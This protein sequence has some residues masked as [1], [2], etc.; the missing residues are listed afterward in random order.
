MKLIKLLDTHYIVVDNSEIKVGDT[1]VEK[2]LTDEYELFE[3]HTLNDID[4]VRQ[5]KITHS[6]VPLEIDDKIPHAV[7]HGD[8]IFNTFKCFD[9]IK[10][11]S[12]SEIEEAI[13][14]YN[15]ENMAYQEISKDYFLGSGS[16]ECT[17][18]KNFYVKGFNAYKELVKDKVFTVKDMKKQLQSIA[19]EIATEDG[20]LVS[21]SP[22]LIYSWIEKRIQS[23]LPKTEW[24]VEFDE[25]GKL[26]IKQ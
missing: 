23:L 19:T 10:P 14:G 9:K 22:A 7:V 24:D 5:K 21:C 1:V 4:E 26:K 12:L 16:E 2:L 8:S 25:N 18:R 17:D 3:I 11:L 13:Y 15:V 6:T 20:E